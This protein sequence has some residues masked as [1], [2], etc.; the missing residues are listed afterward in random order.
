MGQH[1][2]QV[3]LP[4]CIQCEPPEWDL[5]LFVFSVYLLRNR[6]STAGLHVIHKAVHTMHACLPNRYTSAK[7]AGGALVSAELSDALPLWLI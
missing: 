2:T 5:T 3:V 7:Q 4:D 6:C 1:D